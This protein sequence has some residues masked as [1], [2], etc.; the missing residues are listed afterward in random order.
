MTDRSEVVEELANLGGMDIPVPLPSGVARSAKRS[1]LFVVF[2]K[3][4]TNT[5]VGA[6]VATS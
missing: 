1:T 4:S 5:G 3:S 6:G 2:K